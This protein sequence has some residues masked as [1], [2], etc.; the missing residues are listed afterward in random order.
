M[1]AACLTLDSGRANAVMGA[2]R[3]EREQAVLAAD[4]CGVRPSWA[5]VPG[6]AAPSQTRLGFPLMERALMDPTSR[7]HLSVGHGEH[8]RCA[9]LAAMVLEEE[10]L[11]QVEIKF[12]IQRVRERG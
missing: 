8:V 6:S 3:V 2:A 9:K 10:K 11:D 4:G 7:D 5:S 1:V 12:V